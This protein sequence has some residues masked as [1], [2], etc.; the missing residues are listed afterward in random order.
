MFR[1]IPVHSGILKAKGYYHGECVAIDRITFPA[2]P[3][4]EDYAESQA[5]EQIVSAETDLYRINCGG[6]EY[7]DVNGRVWAADL[8]LT[9]RAYGYRSW[10]SNYPDVEEEIGSVG[11]S[12]DLIMGTWEQLLAQQFRYGRG[13][14]IYCFPVK[15]GKYAIDMF[16]VEPWYGLA[17]EDAVGWRLFDVA[18]NDQIQIAQLDIFR[19]AGGSCRLVKK[20][21]L[22]SI[23]TEMLK[24]SFPNPRSNQALISAIR[25][26]AASE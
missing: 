12:F 15:P 22:V 1:D 13:K 6:K 25:I 19:E 17:N 2:L 5:E 23:E 7:R 10:G 9:E 20:Q 3:K 4:P 11:R 21:V 8:P 24:I 14:L 16:F 26:N 18:V